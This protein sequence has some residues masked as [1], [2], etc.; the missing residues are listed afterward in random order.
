MGLPEAAVIEHGAVTGVLVI[1]RSVVVT[2]RRP[3]AKIRVL[4]RDVVA[5]GKE[6]E[7][8]AIHAISAMTAQ[9]WR[10][11]GRDDAPPES[12]KSG[13]HDGARRRTAATGT[14]GP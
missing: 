3:V 8:Q 1:G 10:Q 4:P 12:A 9:W 5:M 7:Q 6:D 2:R 14:S 11:H 13:G